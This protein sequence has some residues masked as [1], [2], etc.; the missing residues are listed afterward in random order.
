M[1]NREE[2]VY[3]VIGYGSLIHPDSLRRTVPHIEVDQIR[4]VRVMGYRRLFNL[5]SMEAWSSAMPLR[6]S[7]AVLNVEVDSEAEF[8]GVAFPVGENALRALD[9][10]EYMYK[11]ITGVKCEE[12]TTGEPVYR[13]ILYSALSGEEL[14][15]QKKSFYEKSVRP[16]GLES[17]I[18]K[19]ILPVDKYLSLCLQGAFGWSNQFGSHFVKN[20]YLGDG[21]TS[22]SEFLSGDEIRG[23]LAL[24]I[25]DYI[26]HR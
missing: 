26:Q 6:Q 14:R 10:R 5:A 17:L 20:T 12:F 13:S 24:D 2:Q 23:R 16:L 19:E 21:V 1:V 18:C 9:Q 15:L 25:V 8:G 3:W 4:L 22:L 7:A 11:R